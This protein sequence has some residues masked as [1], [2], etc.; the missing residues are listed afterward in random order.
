RYVGIAGPAAPERHSCKRDQALQRAGK[1]KVRG[2][3]TGD[4]RKSGNDTHHPDVPNAGGLLD[5]DDLSTGAGLSIVV[6][7][8]EQ[9]SDANRTLPPTRGRVSRRFGRSRFASGRVIGRGGKGSEAHMTKVFT[10]RT[11]P[12][13]RSLGKRLLALTAIALILAPV[14]AQAAG[15]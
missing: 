2:R 1:R 11:T 14:G 8:A 5:H 15:L 4:R 7:A 3:L 12:R 9:R 6:V 10:E 13:A